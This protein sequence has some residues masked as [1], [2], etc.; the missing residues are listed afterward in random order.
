MKDIFYEPIFQR[1]FKSSFLSISVNSKPF[2]KIVLV[3]Q[4]GYVK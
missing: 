2:E 1:Y 4:I 3:S